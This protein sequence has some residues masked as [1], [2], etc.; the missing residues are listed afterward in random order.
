MQPNLKTFKDSFIYSHSLKGYSY[1]YS[2][3]IYLLF[4]A[5]SVNLIHVYLMWWDNIYLLININKIII[6][7]HETNFMIV[8]F[9]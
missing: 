2:N 3:L 8:V 7:I 9:A 1:Y 5:I 6:I 4:D